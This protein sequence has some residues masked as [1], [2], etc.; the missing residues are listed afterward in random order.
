MTEYE[1]GKSNKKNWY[2]IKTG[3]VVWNLK[4]K[5][6]FYGYQTKRN[7]IQITYLVK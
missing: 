1:L 3:E 2:R 4:M 7:K 5:K 6:K